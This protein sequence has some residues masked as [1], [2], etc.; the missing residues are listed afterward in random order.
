[1]PAWGQYLRRVLSRA[2]LRGKHLIQSF[3]EADM[4]AVYYLK[5]EPRDDDAEETEK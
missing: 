2:L 4:I 3:S 5:I 1:M